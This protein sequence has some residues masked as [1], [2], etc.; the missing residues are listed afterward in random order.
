MSDINRICKTCGGHCVLRTSI[1]IVEGGEKKKADEIFTDR[2]A[3]CTNCMEI[4]E[5]W[6]ITDEDIRDILLLAL[7]ESDMWK[8]NYEKNKRTGRS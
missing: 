6:D 4:R 1:T 7:E 2:P 8:E 3:F 5:Y